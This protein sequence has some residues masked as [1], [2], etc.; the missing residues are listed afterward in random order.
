LPTSAAIESA[1]LPFLDAALCVDGLLLALAAF[2]IY[3]F[4]ARLA[5]DAGTLEAAT[6][7]LL[8]GVTRTEAATL[9]FLTVLA[10]ALRAPLLGRPLG[11]DEAATV[12]YYAS[13][14]IALS[15][16]IY[17]SPN[18]HLLHTALV[19][20]AMTLF[21]SA[22]WVIRGPACLAG[23]IL[24]PLT[25]ATARALGRD[26]AM[27]AAAL[28]AGFPVLVDYST[29]ARG[30]TLLCCFVLASTVA[31]SRV[32][33]DGNRAAVL[34]FALTASLAFFTV[35]VA[36]YP[37]V[38]LVVWGWLRSTEKR[39]ILIAAGAAV[40]LPGGD[41]RRGR[42]GDA[43]RDPSR[44]GGRRPRRTGEERRR[45]RHLAGERLS[46]RGRRHGELSLLILVR[47]AALVHDGLLVLD[48]RPFGVT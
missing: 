45:R 9:A 11:T 40:G 41:H 33:Q 1:I 31:M 22:E 24:V 17:G 7:R 34:A 21:G 36:L 27:I 12:F 42:I 29:D 26:G 20:L 16:S 47:A 6:W 43:R 44:R 19:H 4:R 30:Y 23:I 14:P 48:R 37:F 13:R 38:A 10:A 39:P 5:T 32:A 18:N 2:L 25:F 8:R 46:R 3:R 35:P 28:V 15:M